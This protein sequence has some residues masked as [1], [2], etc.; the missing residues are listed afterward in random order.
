MDQCKY[1]K[2]IGD[3]KACEATPCSHRETWYVKD[4]RDKFSKLLT[5]V[6]ILDCDPEMQVYEALMS[7][8]FSVEE[9]DE[10]RK[11]PEDI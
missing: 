11:E 6:R 10:I 7:A 2:L 4:L 1:C 9:M 5:T 8:G 3:T